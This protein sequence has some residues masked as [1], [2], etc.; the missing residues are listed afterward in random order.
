MSKNKQKT[1][2]K[3]EEHTIAKITIL[4]SYLTAWFQI[5]GRSMRNRNLVYIDGF[6]GPG[7]YLNHPKGSPVAALKAASIALEKSKAGWRASDIRCVFIEKDKNRYD[8][9]RE[10]IEIFST[11]N[12]KKFTEC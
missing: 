10:H 12:L 7:K 2:W 3:A 1:I 9:L 5:F 8:H 6:A 4:E 11:H